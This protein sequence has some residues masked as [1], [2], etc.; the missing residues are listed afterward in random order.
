[1]EVITKNRSKIRYKRRSK[2]APTR[3]TS[4][5]RTS[6]YANPNA[7][8][9]YFKNETVTGILDLLDYTRKTAWLMHTNRH[10]MFKFS[11]EFVESLR[12]LWGKRVKCVINPNNYQL[13]QISDA[14]KR[15]KGTSPRSILSIL[16]QPMWI[17]HE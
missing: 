6:L 16:S 11:E 7:N 9:A 15:P 14:Q 2:F 1:M 4:G 3:T 12:Q 8:E 5:V 17:G 13:V 10:G